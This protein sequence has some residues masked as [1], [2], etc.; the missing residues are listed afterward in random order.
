MSF[1]DAFVDKSMFTMRCNARKCKD[2]C[3]CKIPISGLFL[4]YGQVERAL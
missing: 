2:A 3:C 4:V 1:V